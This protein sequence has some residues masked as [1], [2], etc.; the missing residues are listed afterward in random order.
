MEGSEGQ[1]VYAATKAA[2][3]TPLVHGQKNWEIRVRVIELHKE[4]GNYW[5]A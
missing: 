3:V 2:N 5:Y 1:S 4:Y